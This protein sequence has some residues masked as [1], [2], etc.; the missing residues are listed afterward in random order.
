[1]AANKIWLEM[2][3]GK[4]EAPTKRGG[5]EDQVGLDILLVKYLFDPTA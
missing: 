4:T 3:N 2:V 1:M 5:G